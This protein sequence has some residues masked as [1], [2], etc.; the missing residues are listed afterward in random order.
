MYPTHGVHAIHLRTTWALSLSLGQS[1]TFRVVIHYRTLGLGGIEHLLLS[2][3]G[4][5]AVT[6]APSLAWILPVC[7]PDLEPSPAMCT[8]TK[9]RGLSVVRVA[10]AAASVAVLLLVLLFVGSYR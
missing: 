2:R 6:A 4:V 1:I 10:G 5:T 3:G 8:R 9:A 7:G